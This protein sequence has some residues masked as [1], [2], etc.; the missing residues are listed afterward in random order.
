MVRGKEPPAHSEAREDVTRVRV[1]EVPQLTLTPRALGFGTVA[2]AKVWAAVAEV[3]GKIVEFRDDLRA[4]EILPRGTVLLRIDPTDYR[5]AVDLAE[6]DI[7]ALN[8][9]LTRARDPGREHPRLPGNREA[10]LGSQRQGPGTQA[11]PG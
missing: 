9:R 8:A 11:R 10:R 4:G 7:L 3:D 5:L 6:A 2:P 1:I